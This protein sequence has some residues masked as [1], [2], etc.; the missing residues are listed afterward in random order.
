MRFVRPEEVRK[1][2]GVSRTTL[3]RMVRAGGFPRPVLISERRCGYLLDEVQAWMQA[4]LKA[5]SARRRDVRLA[6]AIVAGRRG[7][8][9]PEIRRRG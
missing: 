9:A 4:R 7:P 6:E 3:W 2:L 1:M 8:F 5:A